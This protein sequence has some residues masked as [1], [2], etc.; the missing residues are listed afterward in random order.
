MGLLY[1]KFYMDFDEGE[2]KQ[3]SN[4]P[5]VFQTVKESVSLEVEDTSHKFYKLQDS[6]V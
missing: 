3:I 1:T 5:V 2:W 6:L 4:D